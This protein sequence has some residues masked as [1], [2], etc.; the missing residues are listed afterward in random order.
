V[1]LRYSVLYRG[2]QKI[3]SIV[4]DPVHKIARRITVT[5]KEKELSDIPPESW[6]ETVKAEVEYQRGQDHNPS[7]SFKKFMGQF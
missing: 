6:F 1:E 2:E 5:W 7:K 4:I 3:E